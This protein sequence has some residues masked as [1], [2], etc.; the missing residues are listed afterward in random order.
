VLN[1][2]GIS[3]LTM[4]GRLARSPVFEDRVRIVAKSVEE[5][6]RLIGGVTLRARSLDLFAAAMGVERTDL[7]ERLLGDDT[8]RAE[9]HRQFVCVCSGSTGGGF[10]LDKISPFMDRQE[11]RRDRSPLPVLAYGVR[12]SRL[13]ATLQELALAAGVTLTEQEANSRDALAQLAPGDRPLVVNATP[14]PLPDTALIAP[15]AKPTRGVA[16]AQ[17]TLRASQ[18]EERG[19]VPR[20]SSLVCA[21]LIDGALDVGV[22]YPFQDA[23]TPDADY[24]GIFYR[25]DDLETI[26]ADRE[27]L[28]ER[29]EASVLGV[30]QL[31]GLEAVDRDATLGTAVV[32]MS[33]WKGVGN[34]QEGVL[35][36]SRMA[37]AGAPI[38]TGDGMTRSA[39]AGWVGAESLV[40]GRDPAPEIDRALRLYRRLN[41]ELY[42][43]MTRFARPAY[44]LMKA[45]PR[46]AFYRQAK[47]YDWDMWAGAN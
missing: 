5:T 19:L 39:I 8:S 10:R 33:P 31:F 29:L 18:L 21:V 13:R 44:Q 32:P 2:T 3:G 42:L 14:R 4:A 45:V 38:I 1:S 35:D 7:I 23:L 20:K 12:N 17:L 47:S 36:L 22:F 43:V 11:P 28:L 37:G 41:W 25:V 27:Q 26:A 34:C 6:Q 15:V 16:A 9:T 40:H 30:G 24:Y 46:L